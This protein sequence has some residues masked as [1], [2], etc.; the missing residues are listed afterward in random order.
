MRV[1]LW[2]F[3]S[4]ALLGVFKL[5]FPLKLG[6]Q[7]VRNHVIKALLTAGLVP[8]FIRHGSLPC[9]VLQQ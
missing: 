7:V 1:A 2:S 9:P 6:T 5:S 3:I 8:R 4:R